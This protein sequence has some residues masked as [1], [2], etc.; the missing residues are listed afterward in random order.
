MSAIVYKLRNED[1][2]RKS[3]ISL[4][5]L[6]ANGT[7][8]SKNSYCPVMSCYPKPN[9]TEKYIYIYPDGY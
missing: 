9:K 6:D 3:N 2:Y 4:A 8:F 5:G 7:I 1:C